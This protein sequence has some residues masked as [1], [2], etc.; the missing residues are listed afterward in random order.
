MY[1]SIYTYIYLYIY[2]YLRKC[3]VNIFPEC[4]NMCFCIA[5]TRAT[6][7]EISRYRFR[8]Y[9]PVVFMYN[10]INIYV[11]TYVYK[12]VHK[13]N[14]RAGEYKVCYFIQDA[15]HLM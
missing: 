11:C 10:F 8:A 9:I 3:N 5:K 7:S 12:I 4:D 15:L 1:L 14:R 13:N 6:E 2:I